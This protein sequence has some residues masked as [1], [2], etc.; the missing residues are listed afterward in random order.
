MF[1]LVTS[2][3]VLKVDIVLRGTPELPFLGCR[4]AFYILPE[5]E[6]ILQLQVGVKAESQGKSPSAEACRD[7]F[8]SSSFFSV[9]FT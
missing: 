5:M 2:N 1:Y 4:K 7:I 3:V 6:N 8:K 9:E